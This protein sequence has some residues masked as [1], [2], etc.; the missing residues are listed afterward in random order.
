[1]FLNY[2]CQISKVSF[3][4]HK[5]L[6]NIRRRVAENRSQCIIL[7]GHVLQQSDL[8]QINRTLTSEQY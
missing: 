6:L 3:S 7:V 4:I 5:E 8:F 2:L 1:M